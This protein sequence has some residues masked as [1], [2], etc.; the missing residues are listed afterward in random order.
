MSATVPLLDELLEALG[1]ATRET[2]VD[3]L[4]SAG[5]PPP[6]VDMC[7]T[8]KIR[9][10]GQNYV[11]DDDGLE[12]VVVPIFDAGEMIDL[13][14][15][16]LS[17]PARWWT[18]IDAHWALGADALDL[19]WLGAEL[20]VCRDPLRWLQSGPAENAIVIL[21]WH[22]ARLH[23][24]RVEIVAEDLE[25]GLELDRLLYIPAQH[26]RISVPARAAT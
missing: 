1:S 3:Q 12:A 19:L 2:H 25:H 21:D 5:L 26:P 20:K 8:A 16:N 23:I 7:G 24:P 17:N 18:R 14:A 22:A 13:V 6:A 9:P 15:F 10:D 4:L 11:P